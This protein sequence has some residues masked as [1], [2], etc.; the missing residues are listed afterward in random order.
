MTPSKKSLSDTSCNRIPRDL[1]PADVAKP[2]RVLRRIHLA[3]LDPDA[4]R[5]Y[6]REAMRAWRLRNVPRKGKRVTT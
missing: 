3:W 1:S 2:K 4:R 6:N 5:T